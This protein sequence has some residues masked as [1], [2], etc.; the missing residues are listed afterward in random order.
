M[1]SYETQRQD[2]LAL[3]RSA[4]EIAHSRSAAESEQRLTEA[5]RRLQDGRLATV[6]CG[7]FKRG[8][9]SLLG[10][11]LEEPALF[12]VDVD[13]ATNMV[14]MISY[15]AAELINVI[16]AG[17]GEEEVR[18]I[19]RADIP[20]YVTEQ[21]NRGN[22]KNVRLLAIE[23][24]SQK[25]ATGLTFVDTPGVGALNHEHT[26]VTY[27]FLPAADAVIFVS[28]ATTPL[29]ESELDFIRKIS[30]YCPIVL[31]VITKIDLRDDYAQ[32]VDNTR[33]KL[34]EVTGKPEGDLGR[35]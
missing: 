25:L 3:F 14:T 34:A 10:A 2:L 26:A 30:E 32:I 19:T 13:I 9:S 4:I 18:Q 21:Q 20:Q 12:P 7:E 28:D 8:K 22:A 16:L 5:M 23:T 29:A 33:A 31:F 1:T 17:D 11:L 15:R 27:G 35:V 6:V 24:P